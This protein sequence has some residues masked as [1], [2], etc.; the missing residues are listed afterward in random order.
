MAFRMVR[1]G[2]SPQKNG[3]LAARRTSAAATWSLRISFSISAISSFL[4]AIG[5]LKFQGDGIVNGKLQSSGVNQ[6]NN[7][8]K[9][10]C[11]LLH[12]LLSQSKSVSRIM[13]D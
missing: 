13:R 3:E 11:V 8:I 6:L 2:E 10:G 4:V 1:T 5:F 9:Q 7:T 12:E